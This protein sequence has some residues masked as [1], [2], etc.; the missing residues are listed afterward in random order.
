MAGQIHYLFIFVGSFILL[1]LK[2]ELYYF[3]QYSR[4]LFHQNW[5][6]PSCVHRSYYY[7]IHHLLFLHK[8]MNVLVAIRIIKKSIY[9]FIF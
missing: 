9:L 7:E 3:S 4:L 2:T 6:F 5:P 8:L 1:I